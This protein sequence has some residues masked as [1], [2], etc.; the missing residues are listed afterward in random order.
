MK[1]YNSSNITG[2]KKEVHKS[3][4]VVVEIPSG[5]VIIFTGDTFHARVSTFER[6]NGSYPS[7]L[8]IFSFIVEYNVLSDNEN[9]T[10]IKGN[11]LC[12]NCQTCLNMPKENMYYPRYIIKF[13]MSP[14]VIETLGEGSILMG[15]L[16]KVGWV[17]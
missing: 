8:R 6:R 1:L 13:G 11:M 12:T 2:L 14:S 10:S 16:E 17:V 4:Q 5:C 15:N 9:I 3:S 7:N